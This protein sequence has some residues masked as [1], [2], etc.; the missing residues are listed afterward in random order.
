MVLLWV[1][2]SHSRVLLKI[3]LLICCMWMLRC[4]ITAFSPTF[5][6]RSIA[7]RQM[8]YELKKFAASRSSHS[9]VTLL[10]FGRK[11]PKNV[12]SEESELAAPLA[13]PGRRTLSSPYKARLHQRSERSGDSAG[14]VDTHCHLDM[15]LPRLARE[16]HEDAKK[17]KAAGKEI[18]RILNA[19]FEEWR[20]SLCGTEY[21][22]EGCVNIG[23]SAE[24][25]DAVA[26]LLVHDGVHGAFGIH[27]LNAHEWNLEV[28]KKLVD[29]MTWDKVVAWGECGLDY[30]DK[31]TRRQ[32][33]DGEKRT[34]QRKVFARQL[35]L[36]SSLGMPLVIHT[37]HA[38]EDTLELMTRHLSKSQ[39]VHVHCF[40]S[41]L[42]LAQ[43]LLEHFPHLYI[44]FTGVVTF[45]NAPEVRE[46]ARHVPLKRLLLETDGPY[47]AP[48]PC[49]GRV[50]HP[51]HVVHIADRIAKLKGVST[52]EVLRVCRD[53]TRLV[54]GF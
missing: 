8:Q 14:F 20:A 43:A 1:M 11:R 33:E 41:S 51:G 12:V 4:G 25:L 27:P 40:T 10:A 30:F 18:P 31:N 15:I 29:M 28:E 50:A 5:A 3:Q 6:A 7:G 23:C 36:A 49:R 17:A 47:M 16:S 19:D 37:R 24:T 42:S 46:V 48:E 53:N 21:L 9:A 52:E 39:L 54:Y 38:E 22:F 2:Q 26:G 44:G 32:T 34:L 35:E 13:E 45:K